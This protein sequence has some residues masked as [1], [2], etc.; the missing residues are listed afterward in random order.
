MTRTFRPFY[1]WWIVAV[2]AITLLLAGGI[3][4]YSFGAFFTPLENEFG[5]N[6][7]QISLGMSLM[8]L[9]GLMGPL[10]GIWVDR[11]G[12]KRIMI[13]G[14]LITGIS[15]ACLAAVVWHHMPGSRNYR[16]RR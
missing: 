8:N 3:G 16:Y 11:Y 2:S 13:L 14:A 6:R 15:F 12:A 10:F 7:A 4:F 1:G 9:I 5:W